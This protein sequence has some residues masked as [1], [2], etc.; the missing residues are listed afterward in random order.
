MGLIVGR[1]DLADWIALSINEFEGGASGWPFALQGW[2]TSE[3]NEA[4]KNLAGLGREPPFLAFLDARVVI[5]ARQPKQGG[6]LVQQI[7]GDVWAGFTGRE[8]WEMYASG[9]FPSFPVQW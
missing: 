8:L 5:S 2:R 3:A 4:M 9:R 7:P 6:F 1:A